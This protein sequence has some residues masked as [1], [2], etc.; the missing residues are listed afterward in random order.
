MEIINEHNEAYNYAPELQPL[1]DAMVAGKTIKSI[2]CMLGSMNKDKRADDFT[3]KEFY[4]NTY[5][6][7]AQHNHDSTEK[8]DY[9]IVE[10]QGEV[11]EHEVFYMNWV[12]DFEL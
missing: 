5:F 12:R 4:A 11:N 1:F 9:V 2:T 10:S 3:I 7:A 8:Y 6:V